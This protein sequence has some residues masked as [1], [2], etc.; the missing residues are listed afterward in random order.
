MP[1]PW[2]IPDLTPVEPSPGPV[3]VALAEPQRTSTASDGSEVTV[4]TDG[5]VVVLPLG[6]RRAKPAAGGAKGFK[7]NI[8]LTMGDQDLARLAADLIEGIDADIQTRSEMVSAYSRGMDLLGLKIETSTTGGGKRKRTS[9]VRHPMLLESVVKFQSQ[10]SAEMMPA[11]GPAKIRDD[12]PA[13][14]PLP[15]MGHNGGPPLDG[16]PPVPGVAPASPPDTGA[17]RDALAE[18]FETD[19]NH[20]LTVTASEYY[21]DL[22]RGLFY[23]GYGGT[24][25]RKPYHCPIRRR[26]VVETVYLTDLI[27]S[28]DCNHLD[29]AVRVTH[30]INMPPATYARMV[31]AGVYREVP[32]TQPMP[33]QDQA[34][35][36]IAAISGLQPQAQ[37]PQ[38]QEREIYECYT[39][40]DLSE[41]G[42]DEPKAP[43]GLPLPWRVSID[44][45]S[46][47]VLEIQRNWKEG[48]ANYLPRKRFVKYG[49]IPGLGFLD[50]G[51]LHLL[52]NTTRALTAAW[53]ILL[54]AGM[55]SNFPGGLIKKGTRQS[56]NELSPGPGEWV[57]VDIGG[58]QKIADALMALPYKEPSA[59]FIQF[60][61]MI[62]KQAQNLGMQPMI[63]TGEGSTNVPV[64]TI[65]AHIEQQT[66]TMSAVHKRLHR[67]Q[68]EELILLRELF[69]EDPEALWKFARKPARKW[70]AAAELADLDL[71]PASDPNV[72]SHVHRLM[73]ATALK[74]LS[75]GNPNFNQHAVDERLVR[76]IGISNPEAIMNPAQPPGTP[77]PP[78]PKVAA[79]AAEIQLK[80]QQAER[81]HALK[82]Q[83]VQTKSQSD[84][85][86][87]EIEHADLLLRQQQQDE[88]RAG[89]ERIKL[90]D[91]EI[92][93][94]NA[95]VESLK[96]GQQR[97][98]DQRRE[99]AAAARLAASEAADRD[100]AD[101]HHAIDTAADMTK[102][103]ADKHVQVA[104]DTAKIDAAKDAAAVR[105]KSA[106]AKPKAKPAKGP[107]K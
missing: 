4:N 76:T 45:A 15:G 107:K 86:I 3:D 87:A 78:D 103:L 57:E 5:T 42:H 46:R 37:R 35:Q 70:Q 64:G 101:R 16:A 18:A 77:A 69:V 90:M 55:F 49:L 9:T 12:K 102:H 79:K 54:D 82:L 65:M 80:G 72:P 27:V 93:R 99:D 48:D 52:G 105:A 91:V 88:D 30:R 19:L 36:K 20:Y 89:R 22:D 51:F 44:V 28:E 2:R 61:D 14:V 33:Q 58:A 60:Q 56:N 41:Y 13:E 81:D 66:Q 96:A 68:Q 84:Q 95:S 21:P 74:Q 85:R 1:S 47:S 39:S 23:L 71:V 75:S 34:D 7:A 31:H 17:A 40:I 100:Q 97:L 67:A 6:E 98:D 106:A 83:E 32:V 104:M 59:V 94:I 38:D 10:A 29:S 25:F 43:E 73:V 11:N 24:I 63:E 50:Y 62:G 26:P 8:A 92:A 53:R